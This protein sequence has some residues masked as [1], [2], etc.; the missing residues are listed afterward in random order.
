VTTRLIH[1]PARATR[2]FAPDDILRIQAPPTPPDGGTGQGAMRFLPVVGIGGSVVMMTA[3][4][5]VNENFAVI[6]ALLLVAVLLGTAVMFFSQ[7]GQANRERRRDRER[8]LEYLEDLRDRLGDEE[9]VARSRAQ[10]LH[11]PPAALYDLV[12]LPAR[13]WE[14]RRTDSDFLGVRLGVGA[15]SLRDIRVPDKGDALS[16]TDPFMLAEAEA[17]RFRFGT[18]PEMPMSVPLDRA[19][20]VSVVGERADALRVVRALLVQ[21]VALH[22]PDDV[23]LAVASASI[24]DWAWMKWLPH[25]LDPDQT[26]GPVAMRR[27]A[28]DPAELAGVLSS[29]VRRRAVYAAEVRRGAGGADALSLGPRLVVVHDTRGGTARELVRPDETVPLAD[30][31]ITVLHLVSDRI[32]EPGEVGLRLTVRG[33]EVTVEDRRGVE[34]RTVRGQV[35]DVGLAAAEGLARMLAPLRLSPESREIGAQTGEVDFSGLLRLDDPDRLDLSHQWAPRTGRNFLRVPVGVGDLGE[36]VEVDLKEAAQLGMGPHGLCVGATGSGKSEFLRTLVLALAL[37]HPPDDLALMLV[38]YKGGATFA[39]FDG[40]PHLAGIITNLEDDSGLVQRAYDSLSGEVQRRQLVLKQAGNVA[41]ITDYRRLRGDRPDL[42]ALPHLMVFIDEFGELLTAKP[43]FIDLFLSI[44]RIGRSIGVH[45]L[46][47]SQRVEGGM[48]R[49]LETYLSYRLG[50]RT[51]SEDESRTVLD[52]GDAFHLPP[53]PGFGYLKVDTSVYARFKAAYVSGAWGGGRTEDSEDT[54]RR[55][56]AVPYPELNTLAAAEEAAAVEEEDLLPERTTDPT[57]LEV[58]VRQVFGQG[59]R[60]RQIWLPPLPMAVPLD[61]AVGSIERTDQGLRIAGYDEGPMRVPLGVLDDP[62]RQWQ[63]VWTLDLTTAGGHAAVIGAPQSGKTNLLRSVVA[64]LAL[65]HTPRQVAVYAIDLTGGGLQPLSPFPHVGGVSARSDR[66]RM[67]RTVE[68]VHAMLAQREELFRDRRIDSIDRLRQLHAAGD[69]PELATADVVLLID[70]FGELREDE[71]ESL[72]ESIADLL[73]RGGGF[74]IHVVAAMLRWNDVRMALQT[75][76]GTQIEMRLN[77][78]MDSNHGRVLAQTLR[79]DQP[80]R[81]L[82][83][84]KLF[85]HVALAAAGEV[86]STAELGNATARLGAKIADAWTGDRAP[87]VRVLPHQLAA[88]D[89]PDVAAERQVVPIGLDEK[90]LA[91]VLL[92]LFGRDQ[93]LIVLGDSEC[94]KTNLIRLIARGLSARYGPEELSFAVMDPRRSLRSAVDE[95]HLGGYAGNVRAC[96]GLAAGVTEVLEKRLPDEAEPLP[97]TGE[98]T[99]SRVV[100]LIDDYDLLSAAGQAPLDDLLPYIPSARDIGLHFVVTRRV[101]GASRAL[102]DPFLMTLQESG[103]SGLIMSG[104][105]SEGYLLDDVTAAPQPAGRGK[106]VRRGQPV[107]LIQTASLDHSKAETELTRE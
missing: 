27:L 21:V 12:R 63:G 78:P 71:F 98:S 9:R 41:N 106:L 46:L 84:K 66:D 82:T 81:A 77:D 40:L 54:D 36:P 103:A 76:I 8:Y 16:P 38:D 1:R 95:S 83:D 73:Q 3:L 10:E 11:P 51:F 74:G 25:V 30:M 43:D 13:L 93:H 88:A 92:D 14:R 96:G 99:W 2:P 68:E 35:D 60:V 5:G 56:K 89:L 55:P 32:D 24:E 20:N 70:G 80:G 28:E 87:A 29:D 79:A 61:A 17:L 57:T 4:R 37:T 52:T 62:T 31:G 75:T 85:G 59:E 34:P 67:R 100:V 33:D 90:A 6:G 47:S 64:G 19:G 7:R 105:R 101:A 97:A 107:R 42:P 50:L 72:E 104:E 18:S 49:G 102:F 65:T 45:L 26:D 44:G 53:L 58:L 69:V 23:S 91:P 86:P 15:V 94:G 22:A 48:L 39:P